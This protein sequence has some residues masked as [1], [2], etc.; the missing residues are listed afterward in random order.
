M[1]NGLK[2]KYQ[3]SPFTGGEIKP[4]DF[5]SFDEYWKAIVQVYG[6]E[7]GLRHAYPGSDPA[8]LKQQAQG[9]YEGNDAEAN[10]RLEGVSSA[11]GDAGITESIYDAN[12]SELSPD[13][14]TQRLY[15]ESRKGEAERT[16]LIDEWVNENL[17]ALRAQAD[18]TGQ[19]IDQALEK[20]YGAYDSASPLQY[21]DQ[22]KGVESRA[23]KAKA[24]PAAR[25]AQYDA[26]NR[27][28]EFSD[29][30][31][32]AVEKYLQEQARTAQERDQ[33]GHR[34]A[35]LRDMAARGVRSGGAEMAALLGGQEISSQNRLMSDL[36]TQAGAVMRALEATGKYGGLASDLSQQTFNEQYQTGAASDVANRF[37]AGMSADYW[38]E[39]SAF[40]QHERD[41][42]IERAEGRFKTTQDT[43]NQRFG[44]EALL[45]DM[46]WSPTQ[47]KVGVMDSGSAQR[48]R[49]IEL[50]L[51]NDALEKSLEAMKE[52]ELAEWQKK[53]RM[54][55]DPGAFF[56]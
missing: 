29:P 26:L 46:S 1:A 20:L 10:R 49:A 8:Q 43:E 44:R 4:S 34:E 54:G 31:V 38:R 41:K 45:S 32:T 18:R 52:P 7:N 12:L 13:A 33:R 55:A 21:H 35:A 53:L 11:F 47:A 25:A 28:R 39:R 30:Q 6:G 5:D 42:G 24:D 36:G 37:N 40:E 56:T 48:Q 16:A 9:I 50:A 51:G 17:P 27:L 3:H 2:T 19:T 23:A 15:G 22:V 14:L